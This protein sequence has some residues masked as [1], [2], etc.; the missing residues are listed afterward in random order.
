MDF[1]R[2][3][4]LLA[5][6]L[7]V[8][9]GFGQPEEFAR[10]GGGGVHGAGEDLFFVGAPGTVPAAQELLSEGDWALL[11]LLSAQDVDEVS[12]QYTL[13]RLGADLSSPNLRSSVVRYPAP[14]SRKEC[15][16]VARGSELSLFT[17]T[18]P[19]ARRGLMEYALQRSTNVDPGVGSEHHHVQTVLAGKDLRMV[20]TLMWLVHLDVASRA[21]VSVRLDPMAVRRGLHACRNPA[22]ECE[23]AKALGGVRMHVNSCSEVLKALLVAAT[24][25]RAVAGLS[26]RVDR[27]SWP[28]VPLVL[29]GG[30]LP[31]AQRVHLLDANA[32]AR[33]IVAFSMKMG[34]MV[35]AGEALNTALLMYGVEEPG[36][37]FA[38][39]CAL[40]SA[41]EDSHARVEVSPGLVRVR[42]LAGQEIVALS[43]FIARAYVQSA[44]GV[45]RAAVQSVGAKDLPGAE[46]YVMANHELLQREAARTLAQG[47][48]GL[49]P[50]IAS[51]ETYVH[52]NFRFI[53]AHR[54]VAHALV[55]GVVP[56]CSIARMVS[57]PLVLGALND[58]R[59]TDDPSLG[60]SRADEAV[61]WLA[62]SELLTNLGEGL[63]A[64]PGAMRKMLRGPTRLHQEARNYSQSTVQLVIAGIGAPVLL[65]TEDN[66]G[67]VYDPAPPNA[68]TDVCGVAAVSATAQTLDYLALVG[69]EAEDW[70]PGLLERRGPVASTILRRDRGIPSGPARDRSASEQPILVRTSDGDGQDAVLEA[71]MRGWGPELTSGE[72]LLCGARA[73]YQSLVARSQASDT[74][75]P[76]LD[77]VLTAIRTALTPEQQELMATA[78]EDALLSDFTVDQLGAGLRQYGDYRL[79]VVFDDGTMQVHGGGDGQIVLVHHSAGHWSGIGP[80]A[81][82]PMRYDRGRT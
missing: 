9:P 16:V 74:P 41:H 64:S 6:M 82:R 24:D 3:D 38:L 40:S 62:L 29:Y 25:R 10:G 78:G 61:V 48:A 44:A 15:V 81:M 14:T 22:D 46:S 36:S 71:A 51:H 5:S 55:A 79:G 54:G 21:D 52:V 53:W 70:M 18:G 42:E 23:A 67:C 72:G 47:W 7:A 58:T 28:T 12:F 59:T 20:L 26:P 65:T 56:E 77:Q 60:R 31:Q 27:Y 13:E 8:Q 33:A 43:K 39:D 76:L 57:E 69:D 63:S 34:A 17:Y 50:N 75:A 11:Q 4:D 80:A 37:R 32:T 2:P 45:V 19:E 35:E 68:S 1:V 49:R 73:V 30:V 66:R